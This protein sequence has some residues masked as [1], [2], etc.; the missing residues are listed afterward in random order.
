LFFTARRSARVLNRP[1][2]GT[3]GTLVEAASLRALLQQV[4]ATFAEI[5]GF[6]GYHSITSGL[7]T[8]HSHRRSNRPPVL[9]DHVDVINNLIFNSG[10]FIIKLIDFLNRKTKDVAMDQVVPF[11]NEIMKGFP[12]ILELCCRAKWLRCLPILFLRHVEN[13]P[14]L[15]WTTTGCKDVRESG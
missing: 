13:G 14:Q 5:S 1:R 2:N 7:L 15:Q 11:L 10:S 9:E 8:L 6:S 12:R 3:R 4:A